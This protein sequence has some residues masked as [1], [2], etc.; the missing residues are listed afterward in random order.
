MNLLLVS[1]CLVGIA[2]TALAQNGAPGPI[3]ELTT[4]DVPDLGAPPTGPYRVVIEHDPGLQTH[5]I[6]RPVELTMNRHPVLVWGNGGCAKNGLT[7]PKYL[8]EIASH[9]VVVVADGPPVL[10][11][12]GGPNAA[13]GRAGAPARGGGQA[14]APGGQA[15][16]PHKALFLVFNHHADCCANTSVYRLDD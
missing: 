7:F 8:S 3:T 14:A 4:V 11:P 2:A 9:G 10:R 6:Y 12:A 13:G 15:A 5:T 16:A 1:G